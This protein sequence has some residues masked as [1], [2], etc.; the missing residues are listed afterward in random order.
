VKNIS[1]FTVITIVKDDVAAFVKTLQS[2]ANQV[3]PIKHLVIDGSSRPE[4]QDLIRSASDANGSQHI[5]QEAKGIYAAMNFGLALCSDDEM[6]L[7]LN[8]GDSFAAVNTTQMII[9][10][11]NIN[12]SEIYLYSCIFGQLDGFIPKIEGASAKSVARGEALICH[13]GVIASAS[14]IRRAG[15]FDETYAIS[16]DHKLLL[17]MLQLSSPKIF[18][19]PIA[20]VSLGGISD[21]NCTRLAIENSRARKETGT[22]FDSRI[23]DKSY[24]YYRIARCKSKLIIRKLEKYLG[25]PTNF[26]QKIFHR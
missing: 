11:L 6:V 22:S 26:A 16:A 4:N 23:A 18:T 14:L 24:T 3:T 15:S 19:T 20:L 2:V 7:Y 17:G 21:Q 25:L 5:Y 8:A 9:N 10:D 12:G 1:N 13:Q